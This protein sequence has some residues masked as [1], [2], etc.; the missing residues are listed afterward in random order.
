[1]ISQLRDNIIQVKKLYKTEISA[2][3]FIDSLKI[4]KE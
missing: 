1:M 2:L 4:M 3:K